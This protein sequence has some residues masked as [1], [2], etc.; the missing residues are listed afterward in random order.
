M[1][2]FVQ[3]FVGDPGRVVVA[4]VESYVDVELEGAHGVLINQASNLHQNA[5][6]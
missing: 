2:E 1:L 4:P 3:V 6:I 5:M